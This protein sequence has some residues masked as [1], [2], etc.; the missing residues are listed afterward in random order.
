LLRRHP[1]STT[2]PIHRCRAEGYAQ[3]RI[4]RDLV[5]KRR[6]SAYR[7]RKALNAAR[8]AFACAARI[9]HVDRE[10]GMAS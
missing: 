1:M 7:V 6:Y 8:F 3:L 2:P 5:S 9:V 4:V 10:R